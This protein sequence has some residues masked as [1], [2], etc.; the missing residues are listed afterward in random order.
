[1]DRNEASSPG[2]VF[3]TER[4][5]LRPWRMTDARFH[6]KLWEERDKRVPAHRRITPDGR[7]TVA[8]LTS[9]LS[10][11]EPVPAPGLLVVQPKGAMSPVGYCGLIPNSVG[12]PDEPELAFEFL[13]TFWNLGFAT[14]ASQEVIEQARAIGYRQLTSTVREW[15]TA[16]LRVLEKLGFEATR[17]REI[18]D[19]HGD[20]LLL[21]M[22]L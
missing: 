14:E 9:W 22:I 20:L 12:L 13:R 15:N 17:E 1:M 19:A 10:S 18:A 21:R 8:E 5:D 4:L 11:Y 3:E 6:R 7:P 16:S 2:V